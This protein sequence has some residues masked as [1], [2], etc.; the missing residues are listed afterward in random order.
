M[1]PSKPCD[2][3]AIDGPAGAG[4]STVT[5]QLAKEMGLRYLDTGAMYRSV[6]LVA[7]RSEVNADDAESLE[8]LAQKCEIV[9][10][11]GDPQRVFLNGEDVTQAIRE[12]QVG[13]MASAVSVHPGV[14]AVLVN[15]QQQIVAK[16]GCVLEGRDATTV[17]APNACL[18]VFLTATPEERA[19]RRYAELLDRGQ[20]ASFE[21]VLQ[22]I[23]ERDQ[24]DSGR[25]ASPLII[26]P[27]AVVIDSTDMTAS[28]VV[29]EIKRLALGV[30]PPSAL[31]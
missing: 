31:A 12:P 9:F 23:V 30:G 24:R 18:K 29:E 25:D 16:G 8:S 27:G 11:D 5:K 1:K 10:A 14:R 28:Q 2:V 17:I 7:L 4:K 13:D 20:A 26:A 22:A 19:R 15:L 3:I 21:D 6:A